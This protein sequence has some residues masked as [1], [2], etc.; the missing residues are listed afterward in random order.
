V[1]T[2]LKPDR[3]FD[4]RIRLEAFV[5]EGVILLNALAKRRP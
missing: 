5:N 4:D 2:T 3:G 1:S